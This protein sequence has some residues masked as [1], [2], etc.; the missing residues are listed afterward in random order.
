MS[1]RA[2]ASIIFSHI[3]EFGDRVAMTVH[4]RPSR[5]IEKRLERGIG[6]G[7]FYGQIDDRAGSSDA[8]TMLGALSSYIGCA[9][10]G[11]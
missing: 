1:A 5:S 6:A 9:R 3:R 10:Q 4:R 11:E 8:T 7:D 2:H